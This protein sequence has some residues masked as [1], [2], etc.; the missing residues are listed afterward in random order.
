MSVGEHLLAASLFLGGAVACAAGNWR[1]AVRL[2]VAE[3][4]EF[5]HQLA[6]WVP[7]MLFLYGLLAIAMG[8][9]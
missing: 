4:G 7:W 9:T 1:V 5:V 8:L 6:Y 2:G 3:R